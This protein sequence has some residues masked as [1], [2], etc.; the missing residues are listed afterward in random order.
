[1]TALRCSSSSCPSVGGVRLCRGVQHAQDRRE[2][3][4]AVEMVSAGTS[5]VRHFSMESVAVLAR[6]R[7]RRIGVQ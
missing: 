6:E 3:Q 2:H 1:M 7:P 5:E 4:F